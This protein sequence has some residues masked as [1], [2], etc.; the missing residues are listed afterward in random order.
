MKN[1]FIML[2][3]MG[4]VGGYLMRGGVFSGVPPV[5]VRDSE[6]FVGDSS[7]DHAYYTMSDQCDINAASIGYDFNSWDLG[8]IVPKFGVRGLISYMD[9]D[10]LHDIQQASRSTGSCMGC[11]LNDCQ[12]KGEIQHLFLIPRDAAAFDEMRHA[13]IAN[14][15]NFHLSGHYLDFQSGSA[16]GQRINSAVPGTGYFLVDG[17]GQN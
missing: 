3:A 7:G 15:A 4:V 11:Y 5:T 13:D 8:N 10:R 12:Q 16:S 6:V 2:L 17:I 14:G 9:P 1:I